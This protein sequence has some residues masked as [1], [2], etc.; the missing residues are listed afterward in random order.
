MI[1][2][3][4][5][6]NIPCKCSVVEY[7]PAIEA[8]YGGSFGESYA[9]EGSHFDF[10]ILDQRGKRALWLEKK[11][12]PTDPERLFQEFLLTRKAEDYGYY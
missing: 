8:R 4:H 10:D 2:D 5:V 1:F 7:S 9:P 6:N 3:T 11:L 12:T